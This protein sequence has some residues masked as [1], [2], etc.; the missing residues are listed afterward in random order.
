VSEVTI[1]LPP[2]PVA[3]GASLRLALTS[4]AVAGSVTLKAT[5]TLEQPPGGA[6]AV[7]SVDGDRIGTS[8]WT[9]SGREWR[10][11]IT[12][13]LAAGTR[14]VQVQFG[15]RVASDSLTVQSAGGGEFSRTLKISSKGSSDGTPIGAGYFPPGV[16][17]TEEEAEASSSDVGY[18]LVTLKRFNDPSLVMPRWEFEGTAEPSFGSLV[19]F[20]CENS[21]M[22]FLD[23][24]TAGV[25]SISAK[26][27]EGGETLTYGP[28][29]ITVT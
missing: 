27:T 23:N 7:W 16:V 9:G 18:Y 11:E 8:T 26:I 17:T 12:T 19:F 20:Y 15:A 14:L 6:V 21:L 3:A 29:T 22:V 4:P 13:T 28:V 24:C 1:V 2:D 25:Y 5:A 10:T